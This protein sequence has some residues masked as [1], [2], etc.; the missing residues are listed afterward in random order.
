M[1]NVGIFTV[2]RTV[3]VGEGEVLDWKFD[4]IANKHLILTRNPESKITLSS[5]SPTETCT[6]C[7]D[8][9]GTGLINF[10]VA[11][12]Q[13]LMVS[14]DGSIGYL[15]LSPYGFNP[16]GQIETGISCSP[17]GQLVWPSPDQEVV[18][19]VSKEKLFLMSNYSCELLVES[20]I[21]Q[22]VNSM[23]QVALG[24]GTKQ[25]QFHGSEGKQAALSVGLVPTKPSYLHP[26]FDTKES[27]GICWRS[28][29]KYFA[30]S[31]V[32]KESNVSCRAV[33]FF[34]KSGE[35]LGKSEPDW[36]IVGSDLI[37]WK[38]DSLLVAMIAYPSEDPLLAASIVFWERNGLRHGGFPLVPPKD[39]PHPT[40]V[41]WNSDASLLMVGWSSDNH[42]KVIQLYSSSNFHWYLKSEFKYESECIAHFH[43]DNPNIISRFSLP[44]PNQSVSYLER[45]VLARECF[46]DP[47][48]N[49]SVFVVDGT[50]LLSTPFQ[51][52]NIPPPMFNKTIE[53]VPFVPAGF[54]QTPDCYWV[55]NSNSSYLQIEKSSLSFS[56]ENNSNSTE[57]FF[58]FKFASIGKDIFTIGFEGVSQQVRR[59][60][61]PLLLSLPN[62]SIT[63]L[64]PDSIFDILYFQCEDGSLYQ[65]DPNTLLI[66]FI[67]KLDFPCN[68]FEWPFPSQFPGLFVAYSSEFCWLSVWQLIEGKVSCKLKLFNVNSWCSVE[69]GH[70]L[71]ASVTSGNELKIYHPQQLVEGDSMVEHS[72]R[73]VEKGAYIVTAV[74]QSAGLVLGLPRGNLET[75]FPRAMLLVQIQQNL[76]PK[77]QWKEAFE[78]S[79]KHRIDLNILHSTV[80]TLEFIEQLP[81]FVAQVNRP[82]WLNL[83][84]SSL[85]TDLPNLTKLLETLHSQLFHNSARYF[86]PI[87]T[88]YAKQ[89]KFEDALKMI[90]SSYSP[91][92]ILYDKMIK[93]LLFLQPSESFL[94][95]VALRLCD[96]DCAI[97][98]AKRS[99][100]DPKEYQ[101]F[102]K[103]LST[104][105]DKN[106]VRFVVNDYLE[107]W[108]DALFYLVQYSIENPTVTLQPKFLPPGLVDYVKRHSLYKQCLALL[109]LS[110]IE[111][112]ADL[113]SQLW[114]C[115][116][117]H[118]AK[119]G[120]FLQAALAIILSST[121]ETDFKTGK[122][123]EAALRVLKNS[124]RLHEYWREAVGLSNG[125]LID[126][127]IEYFGKAKPDRK[128][129]LN[130]HNLL[131]QQFILSNPERPDP[132]SPLGFLARPRPCNTPLLLMESLCNAHC[133]LDA[134][135]F[136]ISHQSCREFFKGFVYN[137]TTVV[138]QQCKEIEQTFQKRFS[139]L[140][141]ARDSYQRS[142]SHKSSLDAQDMTGVD[143]D[144]LS[145]I[146]HLSI[147]TGTTRQSTKSKRKA[148]KAKLRSREG[149]IYEEDYLL[150]EI[151]T[152]CFN[153]LSTLVV[154]PGG[155][156]SCEMKELL[157]CLLLINRIDLVT[158][159]QTI[160]QST[161]SLLNE[162]LVQVF[163]Q[164]VFPLAEHDTD[165]LRP[166]ERPSPLPIDTWLFEFVT[167]TK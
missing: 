154:P 22:L 31:I 130:Y 17:N 69:L 67:D 139:R 117:E 147:L 6:F 105:P 121:S 156:D 53:N 144:T 167:F 86:E 64:F 146:S 102:V 10:S 79:R 65:L 23:P 145:V 111:S 160:L 122:N 151:S 51:H 44:T 126:E 21:D 99:Q 5:Q 70:F 103:E 24:W 38:P 74:P 40:V 90:Q 83:F 113:T 7:L 4:T 32:E 30:L 152:N 95:R 28:D 143:V 80:G 59:N 56:N 35:L 92:D 153:K 12:D 14:D 142:L 57:S 112:P 98:I 19:L 110:N 45:L 75:V 93:Y 137:R 159:L 131:V 18:V 165:Y 66:N 135:R 13:L 25:T 16:I 48:N 8:F 128:S 43:P 73:S 155:S 63:S 149:G 60:S 119:D 138:I 85:P 161:C 36:S 88:C 84:I 104:I 94:Y 100:M 124:G 78:L 34:S 33:Y 3:F 29:S 158:Q 109:L 42:V 166:W 72:Q 96:W 11:S 39:C 62:S 91:N 1:Q 114:V 162:H 81:S 116:S 120:Q 77:G 150:Y 58:T 133:W 26:L 52:C 148:T 141:E 82:D 115:Y 61:L 129:Q 134:Y 37:S 55:W 47:N 20:R 97:A 54:Y 118:L 107:R 87:L 50:K 2:E 76:I 9:C 71:M 136:S 89:G 127:L 41:E 108:D 46:A 49:G 140:L 132:P 164:V 106:V 101:G 123:Q 125:R 157:E 15:T 163:D 27:I 68:Q